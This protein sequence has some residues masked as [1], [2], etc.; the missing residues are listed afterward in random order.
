MLISKEWYINQKE[1]L[2][3]LRRECLQGESFLKVG[4]P[5]AILRTLGAR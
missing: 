2:D 3:A 1:F 4:W 5:F